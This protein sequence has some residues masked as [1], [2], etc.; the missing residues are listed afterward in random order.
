M[1]PQV[2]TRCCLTKPNCAL[3]GKSINTVACNVIYRDDSVAVTGDGEPYLHIIRQHYREYVLFS[4]LC[5]TIRS[6]I[7]E[8]SR[9]YRGNPNASGLRTVKKLWCSMP[10]SDDA[11]EDK[12]VCTAMSC[13]T[14]TDNKT[15]QYLRNYRWFCR[16]RSLR[17][18]R[19]RKFRLKDTQPTES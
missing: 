12:S 9:R 2:L 17:E 5:A 14:S 19:T 4:F 3:S 15:G 7:I 13:P 6:L 8:L 10:P 16:G 18:Y 1:P 11:W